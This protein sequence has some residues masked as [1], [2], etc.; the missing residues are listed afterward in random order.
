VG[1]GGEESID[2]LEVGSVECDRALQV[3]KLGYLSS[4]SLA[5]GGVAA[6]YQYR[7]IIPYQV[8]IAA[9]ATTR[10][11][12]LSKVGNSNTSCEIQDLLSL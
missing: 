8:I 1:H 2:K 3:D 11:N 7:S 12:S 10:C 4:G 9:I 5:D 6:A